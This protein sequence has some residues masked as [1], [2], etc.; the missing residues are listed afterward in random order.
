[1]A[2]SAAHAIREAQKKSALYLSP[3]SAWEIGLLASRGRVRLP[4]SVE[5]HVERIFSLPGVQIAA[6]TPEIAVRSTLLPG[7]FP[8]V[9]ADRMLIATAMILGLK[10]VT[11][12]QRILDYGSQGFLP[13]LAC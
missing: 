3:I 12:D 6:L 2:A 9:P 5:T 11:R 4:V 7:N 13:V 10:L 8:A 1:M